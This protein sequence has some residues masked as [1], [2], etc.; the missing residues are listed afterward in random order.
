MESN[1]TGVYRAE[2]GT[3]ADANLFLFA[4]EI[5]RK[6]QWTIISGDNRVFNQIGTCNIV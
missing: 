5:F 1:R 2:D 3:G 4:I 6:I